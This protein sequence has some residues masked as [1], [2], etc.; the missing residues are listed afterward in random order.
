MS[1]LKDLTDSNSVA[2]AFIHC[3]PTAINNCLPA[4]QL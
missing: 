1:L 4:F 3:L 2:S